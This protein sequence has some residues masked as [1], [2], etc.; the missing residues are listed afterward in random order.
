MS[1]NIEKEDQNEPV[2]LENKYFL[3]FM[4][5]K[6]QLLRADRSSLNEI[7]KVI[8]DLQMPEG[9]YYIMKGTAVI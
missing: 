3:I 5:G 8:V 9:S 1:E 6:N 7:Y 4:D 2:L